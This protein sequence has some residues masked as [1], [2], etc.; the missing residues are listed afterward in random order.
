[1]IQE[2]QNSIVQPW[3]FRDQPAMTQGIDTGQVHSVEEARGPL[4]MVSAIPSE[5]QHRYGFPATRATKVLVSYSYYQKD[6]V[7]L[8][9]F[10]F[11]TRVAM[12]RSHHLI[13]PHDTDTFIVVN[14]RKCSPCRSLLTK[15]QEFNKELLNT[16]SKAWMGDGFTLL[17]RKQNIGMDFAAHNVRTYFLM[18][19]DG[20]H[21]LNNRTR[22]EPA[23]CSS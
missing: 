14:T 6:K 7:Q 12:G 8:E 3:N 9:N 2:E 1:M 15:A 18:I 13:R 16:V 22:I 21:L 10:Q 17:L 4:E 5:H 20:S 19:S 11:F 23:I